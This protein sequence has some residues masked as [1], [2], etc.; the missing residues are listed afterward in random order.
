MYQISDIILIFDHSL[1]F[2]LSINTFVVFCL[3]LILEIKYFY[4]PKKIYKHSITIIS[5]IE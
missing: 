1:L 2:V 3:F 5:N 4:T